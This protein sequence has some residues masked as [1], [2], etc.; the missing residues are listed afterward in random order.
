MSIKKI[1]FIDDGP[2]ISQVE[3][4]QRNAKQRGVDI[5]DF[6][7]DLQ[8]QRFRKPDPN[9]GAKQI[10]DFDEIKKELIENHF[11]QAYD[12]IACD[13]YYAGDD[14]DGFKILKWLKGESS[15]QRKRIRKSKLMLYSSEGDRVAEKTNTVEDLSR[16]VRLGLVDFLQRDFLSRDVPGIISSQ[17]TPYNF[18]SRLLKELESYPN[19]QFQSVYPKFKGKKL[20]EIAEAI[21][22]EESNGLE[23]QNNL[24]ELTIA[25][26]INLNHEEEE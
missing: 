2:L 18:A 5:H 13:Y 22:R 19:F 3:K 9:D 14:I 12:L 24:I 25:H 23:F 20:S 1:L 6:Y 21:D 16:L 11:D 7:I 10:L 4:L 26:L 15:S 8:E 17:E